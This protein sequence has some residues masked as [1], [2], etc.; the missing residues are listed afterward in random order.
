M[1]PPNLPDATASCLRGAG[2]TGGDALKS[3]AKKRKRPRTSESDDGKGEPLSCP[4]FGRSLSDRET[5]ASEYAPTSGSDSE[6]SGTKRATMARRRRFCAV[7]ECQNA[8]SRKGRR[9]GTVRTYTVP[10]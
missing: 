3:N 9:C 8:A 2:R 7:P 5:S 4:P 10:T 1:D 6:F